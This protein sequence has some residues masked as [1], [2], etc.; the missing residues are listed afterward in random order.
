M[1]TLAMYVLL[2][3]CLLALGATPLARLAP[4]A[5]VPARRAADNDTRICADRDDAARRQLA[6]RHQGRR[7][8][9]RERD[10]GLHAICKRD[11][12]AV[13][14][15]PAH[16]GRKRLIRAPP[17]GLHRVPGCGRRSHLRRSACSLAVDDAAE[18]YCSALRSPMTS[19]RSESCCTPTSV[20]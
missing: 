2:G 18:A 12:E 16:D 7:C 15:D 14:L 4:D 10:A 20:P 13:A 6:S 9:V 5:V 1:R 3:S 17:V 19:S 8:E 11:A